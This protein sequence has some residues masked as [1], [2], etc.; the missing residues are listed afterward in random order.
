MAL[1]V[2]PSAGLLSDPSKGGQAGAKCVL[3]W[4]LASV[5]LRAMSIQR[6]GWVVESAG[7]GEA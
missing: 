5:C 4:Q 2:P 6:V 7:N 1:A 3:P